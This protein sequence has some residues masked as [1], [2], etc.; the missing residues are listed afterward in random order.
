VNLAV[1][2]AVFPG[3]SV[4]GVVTPVALKS[5]PATEMDEIVTG[6]VPVEDSVTVFVAV[7]PILTLPNATFVALRLR[8]D[9]A[10]WSGTTSEHHRTKYALLR[11]NGDKLPLKKRETLRLSKNLN[12]EDNRAPRTSSAALSLLGMAVF[13]EPPGRH[14]APR[15]PRG[16]FLQRSVK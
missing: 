6:A 9:V 8:V 10:A 13:L 2:L 12:K 1:N 4:S 11:A 5:D 3:L 15:R 14:V 16:R 7:W